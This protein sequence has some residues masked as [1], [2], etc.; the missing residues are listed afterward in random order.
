V[1]R[2]FDDDPALATWDE[3]APPAFASSYRTFCGT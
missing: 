1:R 3:P 2:P